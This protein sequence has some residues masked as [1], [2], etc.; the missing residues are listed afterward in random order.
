[1]RVGKILVGGGMFGTVYAAI[2]TGPH[3]PGWKGIQYMFIFGDSYSTVSWAPTTAPTP[4][5]ANPIGVEW[6]GI[7]SVGALQPNWVG[8]MTNGFNVSNLLAFDYAI[9]G[10]NIT[11]FTSQI[12]N[13]FIPT[14]GQRPASSA[15]AADNSVFVSWIGINDLHEDADTAITINSIMQQQQNLYT[16]GARNFIIVNMPPW[17]KSP[18][19][20]QIL[21]LGD[22]VLAWNA[23][24]AGAALSW[25]TL[26]PDTSTLVFSSW[27][28]ITQILSD[29]AHYNVTDP[30]AIGGGVWQDDLHI[31]SLVHFRIANDMAGWLVSLPAGPSPSSSSSPASTSMPTVPSNGGGGAT[32]GGMSVTTPVMSPTTYPAGSAVYHAPSSTPT[33]SSDAY[34]LPLALS[35]HPSQHPLQT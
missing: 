20:A 33:F 13:E 19:G 28:T 12:Q 11:G 21:E 5:P 9:A 18:M 17:D 14:A 22:R 34:V 16:L 27:D 8:Y 23:R 10:N 15:W 25:S 30:S 31:S 7:T 26:N 24:L 1:M 3:W 32:N 4:T 29:P 6:P 2:G 35:H